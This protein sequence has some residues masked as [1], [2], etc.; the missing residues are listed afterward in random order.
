MMN[1]YLEGVVHGNSALSQAILLRSD[2]IKRSIIINEYEEGGIKMPDIQS[3]YKAL[4]MSW[5]H[6]LLDPFNH[7]PWKVL[8][9]IFFSISFKI[10]SGGFGKTVRH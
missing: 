5:L 8:L 7:S 6:K 2:K 1:V 3:F 10:E 4:K 9:L